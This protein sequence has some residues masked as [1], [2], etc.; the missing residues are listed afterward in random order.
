MFNHSC[1]QFSVTISKFEGFRHIRE[2]E[3]RRVIN[4]SNQKYC[5]LDPLSPFIIANILDDIA[6]C[7]AIHV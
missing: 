6:L 1:I 7:L 2:D 3:L 4:T 5:D